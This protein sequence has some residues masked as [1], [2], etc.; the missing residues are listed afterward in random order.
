MPHLCCIYFLAFCG[1]SLW[2]ISKYPKS[3]YQLNNMQLWQ[4]CLFP[5]IISIKQLCKYCQFFFRNVNDSVRM[6]L[7]IPITVFILN[8]RYRCSIVSFVTLYDAFS[9]VEITDGVERHHQ[10]T[11]IHI[12]TELCMVVH[13]GKKLPLICKLKMITQT[14]VQL[15]P[16]C[17]TL[18]V[19]VDALRVYKSGNAAF[20]AKHPR[21]R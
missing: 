13:F 14:R 17:T 21:L 7:C 9:I 3:I 4:F 19:V 11:T 12:Q 10:W 5:I 2:L 16:K 15:F 6:S 1:Y 20:T 18:R 8:A